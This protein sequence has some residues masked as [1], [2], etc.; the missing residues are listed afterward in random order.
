MKRIH[1][2]NCDCAEGQR[3]LD[4]FNEWTECLECDFNLT[5]MELDDL[6]YS[7]YYDNLEAE[8]KGN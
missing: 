3:Y 7:D 1:Y 6:T 8:L 4:T 5:D 2:E